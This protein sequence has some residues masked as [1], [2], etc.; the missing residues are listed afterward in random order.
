MLSART[1]RGSELRAAQV[2]L[3]P[4]VHPRAEVLPRA[5]QLASE[6]AALPSTASRM[7]H[8]HLAR[9]RRAALD[10]AL[11]S[12]VAMHRTLF[13]LPETQAALREAYAPVPGEEP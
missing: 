12:E 1:L 4:C 3:S 13:A 9:Q 10:S 2:P 7:A 11:E 6:M 8:Q 5:L